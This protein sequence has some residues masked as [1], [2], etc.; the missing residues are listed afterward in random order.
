VRAWPIAGQIR[1]RRLPWP[2]HLLRSG[3]VRPA[4]TRAATR[5]RLWLSRPS[6]RGAPTI[7]ANAAAATGRAW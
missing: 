7:G 4:V 2:D 1:G 3:R 6:R 5:A